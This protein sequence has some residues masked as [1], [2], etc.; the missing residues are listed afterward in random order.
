MSG[1][2]G[3]WE[4]LSFVDWEKGEDGRYLGQV[5]RSTYRKPFK[6]EN[7]NSRFRLFFS[8]FVEMS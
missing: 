4:K 8:L 6:G 1:A 5:Q 2:V 7:L 3:H